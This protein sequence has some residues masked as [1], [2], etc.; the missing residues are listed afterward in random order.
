MRLAWAP[1]ARAAWRCSAERGAAYLV[2]ELRRVLNENRTM[3]DRL[4]ERKRLLAQAADLQ[5]QAA[6]KSTLDSARDLFKSMLAVPANDVNS[7]GKGS[8]NV[9]PEALFSS[10]KYALRQS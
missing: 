3:N 4:E 9:P 6:R 7:F 5:T 1:D 2:A 10:V 8:E